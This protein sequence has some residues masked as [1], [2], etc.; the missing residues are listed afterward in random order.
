MRNVFVFGVTKYFGGGHEL[1]RAAWREP[2]LSFDPS[3]EVT[4]RQHRLHNDEL[5]PD[6]EH[7]VRRPPDLRLDCVG[8]GPEAGDGGGG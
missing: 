6:F 3:Q 8:G 2:C 7:R 5:A 4:V 1:L